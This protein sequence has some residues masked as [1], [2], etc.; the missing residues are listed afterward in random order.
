MTIN[1]THWRKCL[2]H[3]EYYCIDGKLKYYKNEV[4]NLLDTANNNKT[5]D[6]LG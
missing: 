6:S 4:K 2:H 5:V 1:E 3:Q